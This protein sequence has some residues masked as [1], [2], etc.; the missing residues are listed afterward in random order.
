DN[1]NP[2]V[3]WQVQ[4][5]YSTLSLIARD[6]LAIQATSIALKQ[7]FSIADL[8]IL[9][10]RNRLEDDSVRAILYLKSW[11]QKGICELDN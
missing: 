5:E 8:T 6:Y 3:W 9:A 2:L 11:L 10:I 7:A 4:T 1:S